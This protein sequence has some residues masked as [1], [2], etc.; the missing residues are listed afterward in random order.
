M[1]KQK[2]HFLQERQKI[3]PLYYAA[4]LGLTEVTRKLLAL[5]KKSE[6]TG[7]G[8][9]YGDE[10]RVACFFQ[11]PDAISL[12]LDAGADTESRGGLFNTSLG[13][14][15]HTKKPDRGIIRTLIRR[16]QTLDEGDQVIGW[17]LRWA[18]MTDEG[19]QVLGW[20]LRWAAMTDDVEL[21]QEILSRMTS[22]PLKSGFAFTTIAGIQG[23]VSGTVP[24]FS[25]NCLTQRGSYTRDNSAPYEAAC[26]GNLGVLEILIKRWDNIN[27]MDREGRTAL[28]WAVF[29]THEDV[30]RLL[31]QNGANCD[32]GVNHYLWTPSYWAEQ[33]NHS[34][35]RSLLLEAGDECHSKTDRQ[36]LLGFDLESLWLGCKRS[37][38][39]PSFD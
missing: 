28:Y 2:K 31:L 22:L 39:G 33:K 35:I 21:V 29:K 7:L 12:L 5:E 11:H 34:A 17:V 37:Q 32:R 9:R 20:V 19:D 13:A 38:L 16:R 6:E 4:R 36:K 1:E 14:T 24:V 18:A 8:D 15:M 26:A 30:V 3:R 25:G 27:E 23:T 10:L